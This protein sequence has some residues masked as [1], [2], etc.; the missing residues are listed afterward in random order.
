VLALVGETLDQ[1]DD[2]TGAVVSRRKAGDR[3]AIWTKNRDDED[4]IINIG[5]KNENSCWDSRINTI[6]L[7]ES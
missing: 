1:N 5:K 4:S 3:C 2:I 7:S 6:E